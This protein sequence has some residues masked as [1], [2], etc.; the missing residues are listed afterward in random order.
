LA[1]ELYSRIAPSYGEPM[2]SHAGRRLVE[3]AGVQPGQHVLD[4]A[5]GRGAVL[6][7][8]AERV[9][10]DGAVTGIDLAPGMVEQTSHEITAHGLANAR[11]LHMDAEALDFDA[12]QFDH[13]LCSFGVFWF[14]DLD[15][16]LRNVRRVLVPGG[17]AGFAFARGTDPRWAWYEQLLGT[18]VKLEASSGLSR[19][20]RAPGVLVET[21]LGAGFSDAT[22]SVEPTELS[23]ASPEA[24]WDSL[25]THGSR[26]PL[27]QMPAERL[28]RFKAECLARA[29]Q[30]RTP[31]GLPVLHTLVYVFA[32]R[33]NHA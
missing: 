12:E 4:L 6:F 28:E 33:P 18:Y 30:Q 10:A 25:W 24:W 19:S 29:A 2:F 17:R 5:A 31:A 11:M 21:L 14:P 15:A 22:E 32:A 1:A 9:G 20:I 3:L 16:A 23:F 13:V 26:I 7:P 8:A 27:E